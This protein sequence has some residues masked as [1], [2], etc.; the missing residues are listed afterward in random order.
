SEHCHNSIVELQPNE[1]MVSEA[2]NCQIAMQPNNPISYYHKGLLE[3]QTQGPDKAIQSFEKATSLNESYWRARAKSVLCLFSMGKHEEALRIL[4]CGVHPDEQ[5]LALN[6]ET[7][8]LYW[9]HAKFAGAMMNLSHKQDEQKISNDYAQ[10]ISTVLESLGVIDHADI[11]W[12]SLQETLLGMQ[13]P[14]G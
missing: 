8:V 9:N 2:L 6:Y 13:H 10:V 1:G 4:T 3:V 12:D 5:T 14:L 11:A 7:A